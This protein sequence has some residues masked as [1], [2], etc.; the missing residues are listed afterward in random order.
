MIEVAMA[1]VDD[2]DALVSAAAISDYTM[3]AVAEKIR[4]GN[5]D[6]SIDL[7]PTPKLLDR[8]REAHSDL[9]MVG[10]KVETSGD[11]DAMVE[12]AR[13]VVDR[14]D[15]AFM[16]ANDAS[17]MGEDATRVL[18]VR[19]ADVDEFEGDKAGL[20]LRVAEELAGE[21]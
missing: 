3:D 21:L 16:V 20:G 7:M 9:T 14:V 6:M 13:E 2:A 5:E 1:A 18:F 12:A 4:S 15:L 10:F 8:V 19:P 11:D 17:V